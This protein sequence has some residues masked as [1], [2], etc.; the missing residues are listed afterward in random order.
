MENASK[1]LII[2]GAILVSILLIG[3]GVALINALNNPMGQAEESMSGQAVQMFNAK[4]EKYAKNNQ[5][6]ANVKSLISEMI[7]SN[8]STQ[9][10]RKVAAK[11]TVVTNTNLNKDE[12][13]SLASD[14]GALRNAIIN[15]ATYKV[16]LTYNDEGYVKLVTINSALVQTPQAT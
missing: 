3:I 7:T 14:L 5:N 9:N 10:N 15:S 16:E 12:G 8:A 11:S 6:G 1:A 4:F 13:S 2:A